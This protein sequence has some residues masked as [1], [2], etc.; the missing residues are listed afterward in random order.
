MSVAQKQSIESVLC[1]CSQL[2][3]FLRYKLSRRTLCG[4]RK[5]SDHNKP[6]E[7]RVYINDADVWHQCDICGLKG[8]QKLQFKMLCE[9]NNTSQENLTEY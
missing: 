1:L 3:I 5:S 2:L 9:V 7:S 6:V 4:K 8:D